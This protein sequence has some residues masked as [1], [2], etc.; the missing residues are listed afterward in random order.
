MESMEIVAGFDANFDEQE[1]VLAQAARNAEMGIKGNSD[2]FKAFTA[3]HF[4]TLTVD[5]DMRVML[6]TLL[7]HPNSRLTAEKFLVLTLEEAEESV[8]KLINVLLGAIRNAKENDPCR[9]TF[10]F[11]ELK[12]AKIKFDA[13]MKPLR[14]DAEFMNT[15]RLIR[16]T[17]AAHIVGDEVGIQNGA[18]WVLTRED[19]P[20]DENGV[21][22]SKIVSYSVQILTALNAL[23]RD[24]TASQRS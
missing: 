21:M 6:R 24:L 22:R 19:I 2:V 9:S 8:N 20:R 10:D 13:S 1:R 14:A 4:F 11:E 3:L 12:R 5:F 16:N 17:V 15:L 7:A 18:I 23:T